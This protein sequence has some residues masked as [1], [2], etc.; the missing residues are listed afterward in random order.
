MARAILLDRYAR[1]FSVR[2]AHKLRAGSRHP[3]RERLRSARFRAN[4]LEA[5]AVGQRIV[6]AEQSEFLRILRPQPPMICLALIAIAIVASVGTMNLH[7]V[8]SFKTPAGAASS[9]FR[10]YMPS[11]TSIVAAPKTLQK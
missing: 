6:P 8:F 7:C 1:K 11:L 2:R 9:N 4:V 3:F 10:R 5:F